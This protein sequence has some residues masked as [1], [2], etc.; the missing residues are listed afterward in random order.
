[1]I[2]QESGNLRRFSGAFV[3]KKYANPVRIP[4][5]FFFFRIE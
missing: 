2:N 3:S 1:M 4:Q 5:P